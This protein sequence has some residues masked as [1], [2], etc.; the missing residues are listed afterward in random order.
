MT[1]EGT[2]FSH[3]SYSEC[4]VDTWPNVKDEFICGDCYAL[5]NIQ[6][7][8]VCRTYCESF[9][10]ECLNAFKPSWYDD[11]CTIQGNHD[12]DMDFYG[13]MRPDAALCQCRNDSST[14]GITILDNKVLY[15]RQSQYFCDYWRSL[16]SFIYI[17]V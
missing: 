13:T 8:R 1:N 11:S 9:G 15:H 10:F 16:V 17:F 7:Y 14:T 4:H 12:C 2:S 5:V 3:L 6:T